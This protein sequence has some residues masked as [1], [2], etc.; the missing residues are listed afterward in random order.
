ME[1]GS[2]VAIEAISL[3]CIECGKEFSICRKCWRGQKCCSMACSRFRRLKSNRKK[4]QKYQATER[5][6]EFGRQRQ[7]RRYE[8]LKLQKNNQTSH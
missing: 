5:G 3:I 7:K 4:Q 6:L 1:V 2:E 8:K